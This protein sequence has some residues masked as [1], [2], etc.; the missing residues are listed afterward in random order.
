MSSEHAPFSAV[1]WALLAMAALIWGSSFL[2]IGVAVDHLSPM[3]VAFLRLALGVVVLGAIPAARRK[4]PRSDWPAIALVGVTWMAAP[5]ILFSVALQ[6]MEPV[7]KRIV[8]LPLDEPAAH[9]QP[10]RAF[11][12]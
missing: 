6:R 12:D 5:F 4:V 8:D 7:V 10:T 11:A 3:L 2:F 1:D 9:P